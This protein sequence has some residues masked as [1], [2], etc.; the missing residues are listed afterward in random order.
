MFVYSFLQ[1]YK[2]D[3]QLGV[4]D[5]NGIEKRYGETASWIF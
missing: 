3:L 1:G 4:D 2:K 5:I